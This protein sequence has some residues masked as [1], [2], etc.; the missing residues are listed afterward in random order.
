MYRYGTVSGQLCIRL[1]I[2]RI[3]PFATLHRRMTLLRV[4][5]SGKPSECDRPDT[6]L[7]WRTGVLTPSLHHEKNQS[8]KPSDKS[9]Q[10]DWFLESRSWHCLDHAVEIGKEWSWKSN[11]FRSCGALYSEWVLVFWGPKDSNSQNW[12]SRH[13]PTHFRIP[14]YPR[15][16]TE[17][18]KTTNES[19]LWKEKSS[20]KSNLLRWLPRISILGFFVIANLFWRIFQL[21]IFVQPL[22]CFTSTSPVV[23]PRRP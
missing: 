21:E 19:G 13:L 9:I 3:L 2:R 10:S 15:R 16:S 14:S 20:S 4:Q 11:I 8:H 18:K 6:K 12:D 7:N 23:S 5:K 1:R 17:E 22:H